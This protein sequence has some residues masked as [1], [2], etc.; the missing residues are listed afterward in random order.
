[1]HDERGSN[2]KGESMSSVLQSIQSA[3]VVQTH[4][5]LD[6]GDCDE[7]YRGATFHVWVTPTRAHWAQLVDWQ[8]WT[9]EEPKRLQKRCAEIALTNELTAKEFDLEQGKRLQRESNERL[10]AWLAETWLNIEPDE[11]TQIREHLQETYPA[12][13]DW[14]FSHTL[15]A[16]REYRENLSKN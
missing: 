4:V 15:R 16:I 13:W 6:L 3:G 8:V 12:A 11:T 2:L 9:Q 14:L 10:D 5:T 1:M 7:A